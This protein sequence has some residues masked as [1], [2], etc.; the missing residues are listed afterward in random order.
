MTVPFIQSKSSLGTIFTK[1]LNSVFLLLS[2]I[3]LF[4]FHEI[5][6]S[7]KTAEASDQR[8]VPKSCLKI[9]FPHFRSMSA[10]DEVDPNANMNSNNSSKYLDTNPVINVSLRM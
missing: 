9:D 10:I 3:S 1:G 8:N 7:H 6:E 5:Y 2:N 4:T